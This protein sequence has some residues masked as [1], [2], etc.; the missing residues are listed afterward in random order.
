MSHITRRSLLITLTGGA[1]A[2]AG[3]VLRGQTKPARTPILVFKDPSCG[4]CEKWVEHMAGNGFVPSVTNGDMKP[5]KKKYNVP[6]ALESCHTAAVGGYVIEG[7]V[8][9]AD[10]R[11]LL[12]TKPAGV[13]GLTIPGMPQSAPGMD[14]VP[15]QPYDVL[16]FDAKGRTTVFAKHVKM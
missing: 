14:V 7:H 12:A 5:I 13:I 16:T 3:V 8:P 6:G 9:A 1:A 4:C 11:K 15:F 10:V 2:L